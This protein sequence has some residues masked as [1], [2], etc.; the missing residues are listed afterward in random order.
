MAKTAF[1]DLFLRNVQPPERGQRAF[2]DDKLPSFGMRVS[3]GGSK[4]FVLNH[5]NNFITIG[6]YPLV[7]LSEARTE[8]KRLLAEFTLGKV[9]PQSITYAEAVKLFIEDKKRSRRPNTYE[10]Y[11]WL[12]GRIGLRGQLAQVTHSDVARALKSIKS[13]S[14]YD[15]V[16]VA[17]RIFFNWC[18]RRRYVS[19][20]P[21]VGLSQHSRPGRARVLSDQ[22]LKA[23]WSACEGTYGSIVR[24][25]ILT[26]QRRGEIA[27]LQAEFFK[28]DVCTL[29]RELCKNAREHSFPVSQSALSLLSLEGKAG[30]LFPARGRDGRQYN[31]WSKSK[32]ELDRRSGISD[33]TLHDLR[34]T[35]ASNLAS[36][37]VPPH[38]IERLL[39]H[40][41]GTISGVAA[42]YNRYQFMPE[43][44][45]AVAK[46]ETHLS[47]ILSEK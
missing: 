20:N 21:T 38:I 47:M 39:N 7:S 1:S 22:E 43:M 11:E 18:Q 3:Q 12:L 32:R 37:G 30:L 41:S 10:G 33:W 15:H 23:I 5:R 4:T 24:L 13:I 25:L 34:R 19:E 26:G 40:I 35:Y 8:A 36:L 9:R 14:T 44:R 42:I 46:Y 2:W 28:D 16:L 29:P 45:A 17:A 31:G 27:A 6:R